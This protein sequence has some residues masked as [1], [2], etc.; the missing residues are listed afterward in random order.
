M[1]LDTLAN[2]MRVFL[3]ERMECAQC[4]DDPFGVTERYE[5]YQLAAFTHGQRR[6]NV[7]PARRLWNELSERE[8]RGS[9]DY[10]ALR[11]L[12]NRVYGMSLVGGGDGKIRLPEDYQYRDAEPGELV[13]ARTPFGTTV[14]MSER[15]DHDD[16]R[17]QLAD[18]VT[19]RNEERFPS[20][21]ANRMWQRVM[22]RAFYEPV[23]EYKPAAETHLPAMMDHLVK[24]MRELDYDLKAFQRILLNTKTF[25]FAPNPEPSKVSGGDDLHGRQLARMTAEQIWDS[26]ITLAGGN[27][28]Q[29]PR[30]TADY[31]IRVRGKPVL[32]GKKDMAQLYDETLELETPREFEAYFEDFLK[33]VKNDLGESGEDSSAADS[34]MMTR[35]P[36]RYGKNAQVRAS[37]LP[38]PAPRDHLLFVFGQSDRDVVEGASREPNVGQVLSLMNGFVQKQLVNNSDAYLYRSLEG[39]GSYRERIR[40]LYIA[41]LSRPPSDEEMD[42]MLDEVK[43]SGEGAFRNIVAALVMSSEFLFV[44]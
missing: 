7:K 43:L 23:D 33:E 5:F 12:W 34:M 37:E 13:G 36:R 6:A 25:Q 10:A 16:G 38:S 35:A 2:S 9:L 4:H 18:W 26:L 42:W 17:E 40:R 15:R 30:R 11:V 3:G 24:L 31:R 44:Q 41:I 27:P 1:P 14:R 20:V 22:G 19:T 8:N 21:I 32:V 29:K 39:A 28:D